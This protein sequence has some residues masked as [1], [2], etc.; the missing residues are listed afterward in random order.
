MIDDIFGKNY[1]SMYKLKSITLLGIL[2]FSIIISSCTKTNS[3][4]V[5]TSGNWVRRS[6]FEGVTRSEAS[7]FVI[8]TKAYIATGYD[9]TNRLQDLW[10]YDVAANSW[11]AQLANFPGVARNS[12]VGFTAAGN[13]Y[14]GTGFDGVNRLKD[15]WQY[16]P[17]TNTWL[18]KADFGGNARQDAVGFGIV[19]K[20][21]ISTGYD[22]NYLKDIWQYDPAADAWTQQVSMGGTKRSGA[23]VFVYKN[24]AYVTTGANN[25][26]SND[27]NDLWV[28]DPTVATSAT[29]SGWIEKRRISNVSTDTYDDAYNIV[30]TNAVAFVMGDYAYITTG[31]NGSV[32]G[33]TWEY[34]F[35][36][37][38]WV[39]K[40]AYEGVAR[41]GAIGFSVSDRGYVTTGRSS[42]S[43]FDDIREFHPSE[44]YNAND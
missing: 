2:G 38:V 20:G 35:S 16:N 3:L 36:T 21:Y 1:K 11:G 5:G 44:T 31:S 9:G 39:A 14:V 32:L 40:T 37:D 6:D 17:A 8:G 22:G 41:E 26:S 13:G 7:S 24:K 19:D 4:T 28:F 10:S 18:P 42:T 34:N 29:V 43:P 27:V 12:A 23:V 15:F 25:G 33:T 30:R